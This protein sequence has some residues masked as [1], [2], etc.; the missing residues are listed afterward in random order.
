MIGSSNPEFCEL[1]GGD[2]I[3]VSWNCYPRSIAGADSMVRIILHHVADR[4][5]RSALSWHFLRYIDESGFHIRFRMLVPRCEAD[6]AVRNFASLRDDFAGVA[7]RGWRSLR[8]RDVLNQATRRRDHA[9]IGW[10][11]YSP[12]RAKW[13]VGETLAAA[14]ELFEQTSRLAA[15]VLEGEPNPTVRGISGL[16]L[17]HAVA[18]A[19][20]ASDDVRREFLTT[21]ASWWEPRTVPRAGEIDSDG[22]ARNRIV[23]GLLRPEGGSPSRHLAD[24]VSRSIV[25]VATSTGMRRS[26]LYYV[27]QHLHLALNRLGIHAGDEAWLVKL[28]IDQ[29]IQSLVR[30]DATEKERRQ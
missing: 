8:G 5:E 28:A 11:V 19:L 9:A 30:D 4:L 3:W 7:D 25:S 24:D 22:A 13:G 1:A 18:A 27:H 26:P 12:E 10:T 15:D 23:R 17:I 14:H 29:E 20:P 6:R 21:H 16:H 2:P